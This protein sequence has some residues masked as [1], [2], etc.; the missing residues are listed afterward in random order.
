MSK[1]R[2]YC[3][4]RHPSG[5]QRWRNQ[6]HLSKHPGWGTQPGPGP[7]VPPEGSASHAGHCHPG[8][9]FSPYVAV[10]AMQAKAR[11]DYWHGHPSPHCPLVPSEGLP[12]FGTDR[13]RCSISDRTVNC[14]KRQILLPVRLPGP[15]LRGADSSL[16]LKHLKHLKQVKR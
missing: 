11:D 15:A 1:W 7:P 10:M 16:H 12:A 13:V 2:N 9:V 4:R 3:Q 8:K 6:F 14:M 5:S